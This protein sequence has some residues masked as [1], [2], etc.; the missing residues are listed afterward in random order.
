MAQ[1]RRI[2]KMNPQRLEEHLLLRGRA[3]QIPD[4]RKLEDKRACR[5]K[6]DW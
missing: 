5:K 4:K 1:D 6:A 3:R 2:W